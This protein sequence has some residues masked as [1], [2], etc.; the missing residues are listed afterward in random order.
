LTISLESDIVLRYELYARLILQENHFYQ[1]RKYRLTEEQKFLILVLLKNF[2]GFNEK[3]LRT[4]KLGVRLKEE[5]E[6]FL[7]NFSVYVFS[8][9][10]EL[11]KIF[12]FS[13]QSLEKLLELFGML[14]FHLC[15]DVVGLSEICMKNLR[16]LSDLLQ[17]TKSEKC[18]EN[19]FRALSGMSKAFAGSVHEL[20]SKIKGILGGLLERWFE[21]KDFFLS[22]GT[23]KTT[24]ID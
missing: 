6:Q 24:E 11:A 16:N 10:N 18:L 3:R 17:L 7:K 14:H 5:V 21:N 8:V 20:D 1:G 15:K 13:T 4:E 9:W 12:K 19:C 22:K 23:I 2:Y